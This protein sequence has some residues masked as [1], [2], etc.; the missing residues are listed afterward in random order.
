VLVP[1]HGVSKF[2]QCIEIVGIK[3][4]DAVCERK[5]FTGPDLGADVV[6]FKVV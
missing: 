5:A 6:Q 4:S 1:A 2:A 3:E